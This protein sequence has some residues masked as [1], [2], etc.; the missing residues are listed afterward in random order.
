MHNLHL[1]RSQ[2]RQEELSA[3]AHLLSTV[4]RFQLSSHD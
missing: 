4:R 2:P 1:S 3:I